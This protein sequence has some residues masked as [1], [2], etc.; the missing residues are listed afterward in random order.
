MQKLHAFYKE[1][2]GQDTNTDKTAANLHQKYGM[3][4]C[5]E[6]C[7]PLDQSNWWHGIEEADKVYEIS[8]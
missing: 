3:L 2:Y 6:V 4:Y 1:W 7:P 8:G 5:K